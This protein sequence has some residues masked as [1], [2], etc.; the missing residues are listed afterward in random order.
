MHGRGAGRSKDEFLCCMHRIA[1]I[2]S[3]THAKHIWW[4]MLFVLRVHRD[5]DEPMVHCTPGKGCSSLVPFPCW[6]SPRLKKWRW[7]FRITL[8]DGW[9]AN[10]TAFHLI[11]SAVLVWTLSLPLI[12]SFACG[13]IIAGR[14]LIRSPYLFLRSYRLPGILCAIVL[15]PWFNTVYISLLTHSLLPE[16]ASIA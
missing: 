16:V 6:P 7:K 13:C 14:L 12:H 15:L 5:S 3:N 4:R 10:H 8:E 1:S 11:G 9:K 2:V